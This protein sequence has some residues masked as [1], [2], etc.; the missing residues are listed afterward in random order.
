M[1]VLLNKRSSTKAE[2]QFAEILK[3]NHIP[4]EH[5]VKMHG[6]EVDF[7]VG[8]YAIEIDGHSQ[9]SDRNALLFSKGW[10]PVHYHN[11][12]LRNTPAMVES[13]IIH[14]YGIYTSRTRSS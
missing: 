4:F 1:R 12:A 9:K 11:Q 8:H 7:I 14:K 6:L 5:R 3:K 10:V 2:R 13:D